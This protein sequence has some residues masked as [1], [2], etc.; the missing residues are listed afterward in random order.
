MHRVCVIGKDGTVEGVLAQ[1]DAVKYAMNQMGSSP[2]LN[3]LTK[4]SVRIVA[5]NHFFVSSCPQVALQLAQLSLVGDNQRILSIREDR[6]L[7]DALS[8]MHDRNM[9]RSVGLASSSTTLLDD[10]VV[11]VWPWSMLR[12]S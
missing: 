4:K 2:K 9:T 8:L 10:M 1:S 11:L 12:A 5:A 7:M 6:S 3:A